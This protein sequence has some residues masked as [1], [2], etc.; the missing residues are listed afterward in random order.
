[1]SI[2]SMGTTTPMPSRAS[3][4]VSLRERRLGVMR[5][6]SIS[7]HSL[8]LKHSTMRKAPMRWFV[9]GPLGPAPSTCLHGRVGTRSQVIGANSQVIGHKLQD[10]AVQKVADCF[11]SPVKRKKANLELS[12]QPGRSHLAPPCARHCAEAIRGLPRW[13]GAANARLYQPAIM[14]RGQPSGAYDDRTTLSSGFG[15]DNQ[16]AGPQPELSEQLGARWCEL[17]ISPGF[18]QHEPTALDREPQAGAIFG[19]CGALLVEQPHG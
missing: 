12:V 18:V 16:R 2:S 4:T 10:R 7:Q 17:N 6:T 15:A 9:A 5:P 3:C 8:C 1:M 13:R 19:R 14:V 11:V